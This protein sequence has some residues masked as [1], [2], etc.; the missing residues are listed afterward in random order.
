[1]S[2]FRARAASL[3]LERRPDES[4]LAT[5]VALVP[6]TTGYDMYVYSADFPGSMRRVV[7]SITGGECV[8]FQGSGGKRPAEVRLYRR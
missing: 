2:P 3:P 5:L 7:R 1:M 8:Y 6:V 4:V